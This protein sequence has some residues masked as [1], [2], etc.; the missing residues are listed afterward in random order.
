MRLCCSK[1]NLFWLGVT[2]SLGGGGNHVICPVSPILALYWKESAIRPLFP[3]LQDGSH[4]LLIVLGVARVQGPMC[5]TLGCLCVVF[6]L[7]CVGWGRES[8]YPDLHWAGSA[9]A[10][11]VDIYNHTKA[12]TKPMLIISDVETGGLVILQ[13]DQ[14]TPLHIDLWFQGSV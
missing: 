6:V 3:F 2:I 5:C 11:G 8:V 1:A 14:S 7:L 13:Y 9:V 12:H 10:V 4:S